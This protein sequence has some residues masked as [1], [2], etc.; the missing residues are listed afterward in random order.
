M[1]FLSRFEY[2]FEILA[3]P[4]TVSAR[5]EDGIRTRL[6]VVHMPHDVLRTAEIIRPV[7]KGN[8]PAALFVHWYEPKAENSNR[9]QFREEARQLAKQGVVCMLVE[10]MWSDPDWFI[11]R[12]QIDDEENS[13]RQVI[14]LSIFSDILLLEPGV[15]AH[16]FAYVG[17]DFGAMYG[18]LF[19]AVDSRPKIYALMAGTPR[20][21]DWY[22]Y[23]PKLEG[24]P[25]ETYLDQMKEYDPIEHIR[26]LTDVSILMQFASQDEH[27]PKEKAEAFFAA[28]PEAKTLAWYDCGHEL[29]EAAQEK[30]LSWL[31]TQLLSTDLP[32]K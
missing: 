27:V 21:G 14:E 11:K 28:A 1:N 29:N 16:R 13:I 18:V 12:T 30:R 15:D 6:I 2:D 32:A 7:E 20:F 23:Y 22:L 24:L 9:S 4:R 19:G 26:D 25:R 8:Y 31:R 3:E 10:T 17:H 5:I